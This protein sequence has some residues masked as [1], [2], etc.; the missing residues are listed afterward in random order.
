MG[1]KTVD[2]NIFQ[3]LMLLWSW[4]F[5]LRAFCFEMRHD[6]D[7]NACVC[8]RDSVLWLVLQLINI[9]GQLQAD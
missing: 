4:I 5:S 2:V 7:S 6:G 3:S 9:T 1:K 8:S